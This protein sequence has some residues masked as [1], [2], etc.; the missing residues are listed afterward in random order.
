MLKKHF[1]G[2]P[3]M[4]SFS[5]RYFYQNEL[6]AMK[7]RGKP[8]DEVLEFFEIEHDGLID[9]FKNTNEQE[10]RAILDRVIKQLDEGDHR[11]VAV[12]SP[13]TEQQPL[14]SKIFSEHEKYQD[15]SGC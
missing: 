10:A 13:F 5:S 1:R 2:Y 11:S 15:C 6:Q 3:E 7:I 9:Q 8:I 12:I 14:I 4:I